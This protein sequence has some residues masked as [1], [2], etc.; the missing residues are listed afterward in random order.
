MAAKREM[1]SRLLHGFT[2]RIR[3]T[4]YSSEEC[5]ST[6][7]KGGGGYKASTLL[8]S[9]V[10]LASDGVNGYARLR[11]RRE[12]HGGLSILDANTELP[13]KWA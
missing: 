2:E 9:S 5:E 7:P 11:I 10:A 3:N 6:S 12:A 8:I 1:Y 13:K 4:V